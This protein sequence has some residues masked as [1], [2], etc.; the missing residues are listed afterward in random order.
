[1]KNTTAYPVNKP[2]EVDGVKFIID[3]NSNG[4]HYSVW[5]ITDK[6]NLVTRARLETCASRINE[7]LGR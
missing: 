6:K 2:F 1:M 7:R 3:S 5:C 4:R